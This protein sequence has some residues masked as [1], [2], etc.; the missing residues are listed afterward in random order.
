MIVTSLKN[1]ATLITDSGASAAELEDFRAAGIEVIVAPVAAE[2][3][4]RQP[5]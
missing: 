2:D 1:V 4:I 5:A 3:E